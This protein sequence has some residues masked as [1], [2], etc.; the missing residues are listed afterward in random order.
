V[1]GG[2]AQGGGHAPLSSQYG[3]GVDQ[4]LEVKVVTADGNLVVANAVSNPE[5]FWA[6]RGGGGG[7]FGVVVEGTIKAHPDVPVTVLTWFLNST[8]GAPRSLDEPLRHLMNNIPSLDAQG[9]SGY[10]ELHTGT[11]QGLIFNPGNVSG[12]AAANAVWRPILEKMQSYPGIK[13]FQSKP[14]HFENLYSFFKGSFGT[15]KSMKPMA[16]N[17]L[18]KRH[19]PG[20]DADT[21]PYS[22]GLIPI[23]SHLL[24]ADHLRS[25]NIMDAFVSTLGNYAILHVSP[26]SKLKF[27][28]T[29]VHPSWRKAMVHITG[30]KVPNYMNMDSVRAFA[31]DV[32]AYINEVRHP[33]WHS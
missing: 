33:T 3:L 18:Y 10:Y 6:I 26:G 5:L 29:S 17:G 4:I 15:M 21:P 25:P 2:W 30:M 9:I 14:Y 1:I 32:G 31:T 13:P 27:D 24:T 19:G 16:T 7:T 12:I 28:D 22:K 20:E 11:A 23:D 8:S